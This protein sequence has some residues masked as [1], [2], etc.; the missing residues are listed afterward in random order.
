MGIG[1]FTAEMKQN[2][3]VDASKI[4]IGWKKIESR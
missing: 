4:E 2:R 3:M 1:H